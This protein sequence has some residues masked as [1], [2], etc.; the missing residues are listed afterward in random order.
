LLMGADRRQ[1]LL[2]RPHF[3]SYLASA[4]GHIRIRALGPGL[5]GLG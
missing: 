4:K 5:V 1:E 3:R 2:G